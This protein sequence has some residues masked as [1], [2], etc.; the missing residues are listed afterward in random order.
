MWSTALCVYERT[1]FVTAKIESFIVG[2][3][4]VG[5]HVSQSKKDRVA[6]GDSVLLGDLETMAGK[7]FLRVLALTGIL[8]VDENSVVD[9]EDEIREVIAVDIPDP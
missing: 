7:L 1:I 5:S 2:R 6:V 8:S 9:E 4:A 3:I